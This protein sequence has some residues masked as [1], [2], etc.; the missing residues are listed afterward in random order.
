MLFRSAAFLLT[1]S[2]MAGRFFHQYS[3]CNCSDHHCGVAWFQDKK[4]TLELI[5]DEAKDKWVLKRKL[6]GKLVNKL[7]AARTI[8][9]N[10]SYAVSMR[11]DGNSW[12]V[13]INGEFLFEIVDTFAV[14]PSGTVG[15]KVRSTTGAMDYIHVN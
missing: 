11:F 4:N 8:D 1:N 7:S 12:R 13:F 10:Q 2:C 3:N 15:L 9:P 5:M 14:T 6:N